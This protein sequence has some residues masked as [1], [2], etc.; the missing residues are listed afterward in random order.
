MK[1][2]VIVHR[3]SG[4]KDSDWY[5]NVANS[6]IDKGYEVQIL[7]M[8]NPDKPEIESWVNK[9]KEIKD[10]NQETSFIG[11]SVGCQTILRYLEQLDRKVKVGKI[12][13]VAP[14]FN[15]LNLNDYEMSIAKEWIETP[16]DI[17]KV[18]SHLTSL[19]TIFSDNDPYVS[20]SDRQVFKTFFDAK[21]VVEHNKGH[22]TSHDDVKEFPLV[23][24]EVVTL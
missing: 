16:I 22:F 12:V 4:N 17:E 9:L 6:L 20:L 15:L 19:T 7:E 8:P 14:W 21:A 2:V 23:V 11:H 5:Q 13:F 3:W 1:K 18:K 10:V 24:D